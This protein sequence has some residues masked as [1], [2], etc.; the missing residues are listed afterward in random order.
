MTTLSLH[1]TKS[2][3]WQGVHV[4]KAGR[5]DGTKEFIQIDEVVASESLQIALGTAWWKP[6]YFHECSPAYAL[7]L[8]LHE[9]L[10][11]NQLVED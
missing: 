1:M 9:R 3:S 10:L 5:R 6:N 4:C 8:Q 7:M 2:R 11:I